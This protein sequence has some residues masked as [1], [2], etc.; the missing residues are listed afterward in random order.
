M[1]KRKRNSN[2]IGVSMNRQRWQARITIDSGKQMSIGSS[3][4]TAQQAATAYDN[5]AIKLRKPIS[6]L[7]FPNNAPAGYTPIQKTLTSGNTVGYRGVT[8][9]RKKFRVDI[10]INRKLKYLGLYDTAKDA[11]IAYDY[12]SF[13]THRSA[14]QLNFPDMVPNL[15]VEPKRR[16]RKLSSSGYRGVRERFGTFQASIGLNGINKKQYLGTFSTALHAA[17][18][19]DKAASNAGKKKSTFNFPDGLPLNLQ[20]EA[21][22]FVDLTD[23]G[24][25]REVIRMTHT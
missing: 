25:E 21:S 9:F 18:A 15:D 13:K 22:K 8:K 6:K 24:V 12:A 7:N 23:R 14:A 11:A 19:Y 16:R 17:L 20:V 10:T 1:P 3:Y 5:A 2:Y 4:D